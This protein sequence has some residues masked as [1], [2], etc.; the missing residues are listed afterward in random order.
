MKCITT[1]IT[2][3]RLCFVITDPD[4]E[5]KRTSTS[6]DINSVHFVTPLLS[7]N[8][9]KNELMRDSIAQRIIWR[10]SSGDWTACTEAEIP[11]LRN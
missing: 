11:F 3:N 10:V 1:L 6:I 5:D 2:S 7:V 9:V 4:L 8:L